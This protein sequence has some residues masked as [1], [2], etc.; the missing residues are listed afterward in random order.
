V[1]L[2]DPAAK[3]VFFNYLFLAIALALVFPV[4]NWA[5]LGGFVSGF[6]FGYYLA[7]AASGGRRPAWVPI[8]AVAFA[9]ASL[10]SIVLSLATLYVV[11]QGA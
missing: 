10:A 11:R 4:N 2:R 6:P 9:A 7:R 1:R 3:Q 8:L 5:H